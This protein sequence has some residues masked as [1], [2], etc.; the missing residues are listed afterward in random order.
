[1]IKSITVTNEKGES[2]FMDLYN[3]YDT[4]IVI[5]NITGIGP[6]KATL[7]TTDLVTVDGSVL[8]SARVSTRNI[9]F[10]F[11]LLPDSK[12]NLVETVRHRVYQYFPLKSL[13]TLKFVTDHRELEIQG[14]VE[15]DEPD[16]F[17]KD[18]TVQVSIL[19]TN[20]WFYIDFSDMPMSGAI[21][22]FQFPFSNESLY[23]PL[24]EFGNALER[25]TMWIEYKGDVETG[26]IFRLILNRGTATGIKLESITTGD[27]MEIDTSFIGEMM[28]DEKKMNY[29]LT[30]GKAESFNGYIYAMEYYASRFDGNDW[31]FSYV[32]PEPYYSVCILVPYNGYLY[33]I[34]GGYNPKVY[35]FNGSTFTYVYTFGRSFWG[36]AGA[37]FEGKI[38]TI[39]GDDIYK[40]LNNEQFGYWAYLKHGIYNGASSDT[41]TETLPYNFYDGSAITGN[42]GL[43]HIF[44]SDEEHPDYDYEVSGLVFRSD[45]QIYVENKAFC[46]TPIPH[47][48]SLIIPYD[49][50]YQAIVYNGALYLLGGPTG[51][52]FYK[53]DSSGWTALPDLPRMFKGKCAACVFDSKIYIYGGNDGAGHVNNYLFVWDGYRWEEVLHDGSK[54]TPPSLGN[55]SL[56]VFGNILYAIGGNNSDSNWYYS[57]SVYRV[58]FTSYEGGTIF[59]C[60]RIGSL[61][62]KSADSFCWSDIVVKDRNVYAILDDGRLYRGTLSRTSCSWTVVTPALGFDTFLLLY[63][64]EIYAY[65]LPNGMHILEGN[66][67]KKVADVVDSFDEHKGPK[68]AVVFNNNLCLMDTDHYIPIKNCKMHYTYDG[69]SWTQATDLPY[70]YW[71]GSTVLYDGKIHILG[72]GN[73]KNSHYMYNT[74]THTWTFVSSLPYPHIRGDAA[75]YD[76]K[77]HLLGGSEDGTEY[78]HYMWDGN[79]WK[80]NKDSKLQPGDQLYL[81]TVPGN[82]YL[83]GYRNGEYYNVL[84]ALP[85]ITDWIR[86]IKGDNIIKFSATSGEDNVSIE[87]S[88]RELYEGV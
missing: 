29:Y 81:S 17:K 39:G 32:I 59:T 7:N 46:K 12:T 60:V 3:P 15:S 2:L 77:I 51:I 88:Y 13:V 8:N 43:L 75:V 47:E 4:G 55:C 16:I 22:K 52:Y 20:P 79:S 23:D 62:V 26:A 87:A 78:N 21:A 44:G 11:Q 65:S 37:V 5:T 25:N 48:P 50:R 66:S 34:K 76:G 56:V 49:N 31:Y 42:D 1:M 45:T 14:Y 64:N 80:T 84:S 86:L 71:C 6:Q 70:D 10:S 58:D 57:K 82:K 36:A 74:D 18:E 19:C 35:R 9:V 61:P 24:I 85:K 40:E 38:H 28:G 54:A 41:Y 83:Q 53:Y 68:S 67:W 69:S 73:G 72:G 27:V 30:Y 63:R 33:I